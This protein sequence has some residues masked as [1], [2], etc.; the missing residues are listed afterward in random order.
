MHT[1]Y[2]TNMAGSWQY[3]K[4]VLDCNKHLL[5]QQVECDVTFSLLDEDG[6]EKS[7]GAHRIILLSRSPVLEVMVLGRWK[8]GQTKRIEVDDIEYNVFWQLLR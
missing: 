4:S 6:S 5:E 2:K 1:C 8:E 7:I 3:G